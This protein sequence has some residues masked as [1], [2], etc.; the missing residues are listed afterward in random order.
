MKIREITAYNDKVYNAV[1]KL[2]PQLDPEIKL[3]S[4]EFFKSILEAENTH[5]FAGESE[6]G[7]LAGILTLIVYSIPT[8]TNFRIEDV[9]I[10][11]SQRGKGYGKEIMLHAMRF[12]ESMGAKSVDLT[13]RPFRIAANQLYIDLGFVRRDT[14]V[15]RYQVV[16]PEKPEK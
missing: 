9:V 8:G 11:G 2:L 1:L 4:K 16:S 7:E 5:F 12:A 13:S 3:P 10:D 6:D 14:N 15:Y